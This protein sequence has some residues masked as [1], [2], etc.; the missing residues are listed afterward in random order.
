MWKIIQ[1]FDDEYGCEELVPGAKPQV[2]ITIENEIPEQKY[3][4][5][6]DE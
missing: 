1:I 5:V 6:Q 3:V 4:S 2:S